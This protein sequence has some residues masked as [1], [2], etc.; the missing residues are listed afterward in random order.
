[1]NWIVAEYVIIILWW[2]TLVSSLL[3]NQFWSN[4]EGDWE[5]SV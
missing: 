2:A 3:L 4:H 1:M 5:L